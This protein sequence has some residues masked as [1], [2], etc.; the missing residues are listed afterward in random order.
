VVIILSRNQTLHQNRG[1]FLRAATQT[2]ALARGRTGYAHLA[3][4]LGVAITDALPKS[5]LLETPAAGSPS[6]STASAGSPSKLGTNLPTLRAAD[7]WPAPAW[8]GPSDGCTWPAPP[9][10]RSAGGFTTTD[11]SRRLAA[12]APSASPPQA[13]A[14]YGTCSASTPRAFRSSDQ[15]QVERAGYRLHLG[16]RLSVADGFQ[17]GFVV[18]VFPLLI[19]QHAASIG[20]P[21]VELYLN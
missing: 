20:E 14:H 11:G 6:P 9:A 10:R 5:G 1:G 21:G 13:S 15:T 17:L 16:P 7:H 3:G 2:A 4:R 12:V 19:G 8:I 18:L